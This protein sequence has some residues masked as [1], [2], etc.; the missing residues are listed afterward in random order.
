MA[1][2]PPLTHFLCIKL[3]TPASRAQLSTSLAAFR[4]D[5]TSPSSFDVPSDAVRPLG[6]LHLTLGM[7][8]FPGN[9]GLE[10]AKTLLRRLKPREMLDGVEPRVPA[11][12]TLMEAQEAP[13]EVVL[14][15]RGLKSMQPPSRAAVLYAP[16]EDP[17]GLLQAFCER[18]RAPFLEEGLMVKDDR[19]LLLHATVVNTIYAKAAD[20]TRQGGKRGRGRMTLDATE[21]LERYQDYVWMEDVRLEKIAICKMGAKPVD[22]EDGA[23]YGV[24]EVIDF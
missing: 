11:P 7:M 23:A 13:R 21:L 2:R 10:R 15:L 19:P 18:L 24:E 4:A 9:E 20:K 6:T 3:V 14:T 1:T 12:G 22:G 8:S 17:R 16:P 5:A